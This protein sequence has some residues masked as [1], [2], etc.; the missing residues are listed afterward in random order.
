MSFYFLL[1][2]NEMILALKKIVYSK[3]HVQGKQ[4]RGV[5]VKITFIFQNFR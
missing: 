5:N 2:L 1:K 4:V 3:G